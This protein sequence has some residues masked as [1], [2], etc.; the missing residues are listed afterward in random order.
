M[1]IKKTQIISVIIIMFISSVFVFFSPQKAM[2]A[3][4]LLSPCDYSKI[5]CKFNCEC[6]THKGHHNGIDYKVGSGVPIMA[7]ESGK[8]VFADK[9]PDDDGGG[10]MVIISHERL[11]LV[12]A[13]AHLSE[14]EVT[15][16]EE[17]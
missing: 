17:V 7:A 8:V 16:G 12:T 13:Y 14:F 4:V 10:L 1:K 6:K 5:G 2:A 9:A 11:G 3:G 15:S